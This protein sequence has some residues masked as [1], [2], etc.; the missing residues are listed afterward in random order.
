MMDPLQPF[1][2]CA[3][4]LSFLLGAATGAAAAAPRSASVPKQSEQ[5]YIKPLNPRLEQRFGSS[6]ALSGDTLVVGTDYDDSP[7]QPGGPALP[8]SGAVF[9]FVRQGSGWRQQAY[10]KAPNAEANDL[11][12]HSVAIDGD[13]LVA[14]SR[15]E[16]SAASTVNGN[17]ADNSL[18]CAGA[19]YVYQRQGEQW[20][21]QA[22]LK[23]SNPG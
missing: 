13:T 2:R 12:G 11:F 14:G 20:R 9:V 19:A 8:F 5:A 15:C 16:D 10:L 7:A 6:I 18:D 1:F 23:P 22:Y 17:M 3:L 21:L 4:I